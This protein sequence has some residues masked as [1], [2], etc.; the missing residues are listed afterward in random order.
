MYSNSNYE[1]PDPSSAYQNQ[2]ESSDESRQ[3]YGNPH[4]PTMIDLTGHEDQ[5]PSILQPFGINSKTLSQFLMNMFIYVAAI[6]ISLKIWDS[7]SYN[8]CDYYQDLLLRI[9]KYQSQMSSG[10]TI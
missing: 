2:Y 9:V 5:R 4:H 7:I 3:Y 6:L 10:S 1:K 8:K